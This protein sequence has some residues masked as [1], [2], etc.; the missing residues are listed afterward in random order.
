MWLWILIGLNI[1]AKVHGHSSGN[2]PESCESMSPLH[3]GEGGIPFPPQNTEPP[4]KITYNLPKKKGEPIT[5]SLQG[6]NNKE[7]LGFMLEARQTDINGG[8]PVGKFIVLEDGTTRLLSCGGSADTAVSQRNNQRKSLFQVN[9]TAQGAEVDVT[10]RATIVEKYDI[11]W[12][13]VDV[14]LIFPPSTTPTPSTQ[15]STTSS[16]EPST[17][18]S[19]EPSTTISTTKSNTSEAS[20]TTQQEPVHLIPLERAGIVVMNVVSFFVVLK[21]ELSN[22]VITTLPNSFFSRRLDKVLNISCGVLCA[23]VE[24]SAVVLFCMGDAIKVA[25]V[26][27]VC[28]AL[29]INFIE[30]VI[31]CLPIGQSH[32]LKEICDYAVKVCSVIH[33][34]FTMAVIFVGVLEIHNCRKNRTD[35]WLLKVMVAYTVW[36][37]L[38]VI[39]VFVSSTQRKA[40]LGRSKIGNQQNSED[41]K[42]MK[43]S[44]AQVIVT[45]VSVIFIIGSLCFA[46]A[47]VVAV[48]MS[49]CQEA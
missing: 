28:V 22:I 33:L 12:E 32:E 42:E 15:P 16:T 1:I 34:I 11:F 18:S 26:A 9:W 2:F 30:L 3:K 48:G 5:V 29:V 20:M 36:I 17:T 24:I 40:I 6:N 38:F 8:P 31:V 19:T 47:V 27:L 45:V 41:K 39:W 14:D 23:A 21:M 7:F 4:F 43:L 44:G 35:F 25:L 37:L 49:G 10:F 13:S 46:V